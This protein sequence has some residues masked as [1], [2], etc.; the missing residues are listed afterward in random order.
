VTLPTLSLQDQCAIVTGASTGIGRAIA[1]VYAAA[2][3]RVVINYQ[4][5]TPAPD[6]MVAAIT[7]SGGKAIAVAADIGE[8][9]QHALLIEAALNTYGRLDI[10]V[11][12]AG[13][14]GSQRFFDV[15]E[16]VWDQTHDVNLK[17]PF[18][19]S[20][21]VAKVMIERETK[22]RIINVSSTHSYRPNKSFPTYTIS[23]GG[24][25]MLTKALALELA[26]FGITVNSLIPGAIN[27]AMSGFHASP[28]SA[29]RVKSKVPLGRAGMPSDFEGAA[30]FLASESAAYVTGADIK[31]DGGFGL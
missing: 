10:L 26:E 27:T 14:L 16:E 23:K 9:S 17:G 29:A 31:V 13:I 18:F 3:A 15:T 28:E 6:D 24:M 2:G 22:G 11:N 20:K 12:N 21:A 30:L 1:T 4:P 25:A 7:A 5:G 8:V 19:L